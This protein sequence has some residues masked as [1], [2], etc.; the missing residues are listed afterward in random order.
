MMDNL[1]KRRLRCAV[2]ARVAC[3]WRVVGVV[4]CWLGMSSEAYAAQCRVFL[5]QPQVDYGVLH[6]AQQRV[7]QEVMLGKRTVRLNVMCPQDAAIALRFRGA[8]TDVQGFRFGHQGYFHLRLQQPLLDG[9][10]VEL[11]QMHNRSERGGHLRSDQALVV[12]AG[13]LPATGRVFSAHVQVDTYLFNA[14]T[15]VRDKTVLEGGGRFELVQ[16]G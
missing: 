7:G 6:G 2:K 4:L 13:G 11:A 14:V 8:P 9:K 10:P 5:S 12:M 1:T 15:A 3:N 16:G